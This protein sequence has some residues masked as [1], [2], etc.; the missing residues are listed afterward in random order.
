MHIHLAVILGMVIFPLAFLKF[1]LGL[2]WPKIKGNQPFLAK[3]DQNRLWLTAKGKS[4]FFSDALEIGKHF[5][6]SSPGSVCTLCPPCALPTS[7]RFSHF[8]AEI[9]YFGET[10]HYGGEYRQWRNARGKSN[11]IFGFPWRRWII[12]IM[13]SWVSGHPDSQ[14][15]PTSFP[16]ILIDISIIGVPMGYCVLRGGRGVICVT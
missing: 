4:L 12:F 10:P 3:F 9:A 13:M 2:I 5:L 6:F 7:P 8:L 15:I 16:P 11:L 14:P 1:L